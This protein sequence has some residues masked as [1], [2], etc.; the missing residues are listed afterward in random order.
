MELNG[1]WRHFVCDIG[2]I[3]GI[4]YLPRQNIY[5]IYLNYSYINLYLNLKSY[6]N[7]NR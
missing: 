2:G 3:T 6:N 4:R 5:T 7:Y 1:I